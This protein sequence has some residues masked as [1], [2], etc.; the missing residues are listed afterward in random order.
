ML[1]QVLTIG[2]VNKTICSLKDLLL[3]TSR[4]YVDLN[5]LPFLFDSNLNFYQLELIQ[6][7]DRFP[8]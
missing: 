3:D 5:N 8:T 4:D 1:L 6:S 2:S 7:Y